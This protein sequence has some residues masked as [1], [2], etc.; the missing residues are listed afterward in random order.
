MWRSECGLHRPVIPAR[1]L[2]RVT[3]LTV[4]TGIALIPILFPAV[5]DRSGPVGRGGDRRPLLLA[6]AMVALYGAILATPLGRS[7]FELGPLPMGALAGLFLFA[8]GW[9][10]TVIVLLRIGVPARAWAHV[11]R[12]WPSR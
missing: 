10:A 8:L 1:P 2:R 6:G 9:M 4:F 5:P 11:V 12:R 7:I 3:T